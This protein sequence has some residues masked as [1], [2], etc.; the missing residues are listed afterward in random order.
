MTLDEEQ[1][2]LYNIIYEAVEYSLEQLVEDINNLSIFTQE[3][4][5]FV[6]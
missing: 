1:E 4:Y 6:V 5:G 2:V 3:E